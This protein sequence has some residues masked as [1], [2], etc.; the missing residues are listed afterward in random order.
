[1]T[2]ARDY[3]LNMEINEDAI[4]ETLHSNAAERLF[5][6]TDGDTITDEQDAICI[7]DA[8]ERLAEA[9]EQARADSK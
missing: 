1:M 4:W 6:L 9:V 5:G 8:N 7:A 3:S 2:G